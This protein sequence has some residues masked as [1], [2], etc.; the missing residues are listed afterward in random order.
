ML[1]KYSLLVIL[2]FI[3]A[4]FLRTYKLDRVPIELSGDEIDVGLQANSILR[5]GRD[6]YGNL[7]PVMFK[8][9]A[10]YR[11]PIYIYST[12]PFIAIFGLTELGVRLPSV[13]FG[14]LSLA[15]FFLIVRDL[16]GRRLG[17]ISLI[18]LTISPWHI[19]FSRWDNDNIGVLVFS[20]FGLYFLLKSRTTPKLLP[21]AAA[22]NALGIY[23]YAIAILFIPLL[24]LT[25]ISVYWKSIK[26]IKPATIASAC[27]IALILL[28]PFIGQLTRGSPSERF[29]KISL[30]R[31][32]S[33]LHD[34]ITRRSQSI[35]PLTRFF[36]NKLTLYGEEIIHNYLKSFSTDF[37]LFEG[38]P[39]LRHSVGGMGELYLFEAITIVLGFGVIAKQL[40]T[41]STVKP[42]YYLLLGWLLI[43]PVASALTKDGGNHAGR[44]IVLLP[45]LAIISAMGINQLFTSKHKTPVKLA[46]IIVCLLGTYNISKY[47]FRYYVEWPRESWRFW[48]SGFKESMLYL[49]KHDSETNRIYINNTY[50]PSLPRFLFWY[51][52]D[53]GLFQKQFTSYEMKSDIVPGFKGFNIGDKYYFGIVEK[54]VKDQ[55]FIELLKP[56]DIYVASARDEI[57]TG[58]WINSPTKDVRILKTVLNPSAQ[59]IF[60]ILSR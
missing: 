6:Y 22:I 28:I 3:L 10:E 40:V 42:P 37:L 21:I 43:A 47:L 18:L 5:T 23:S 32:Q 9:F 58:D 31:D 1:S 54:I 53:P 8:S 27:I 35:S 51:N 11:L 41:T 14:I 38:D 45:P 55:G 16:F 30:F 15:A 48:Q 49:K 50:E 7:L 33:L 24:F 12:V 52:Y 60:Y 26:Q 57:G 36:R 29:S 17:L 25:A 19:Q 59:P 2:T 13:F 56:G 34:L 4:I 44:L 20:L 46:I 39:I